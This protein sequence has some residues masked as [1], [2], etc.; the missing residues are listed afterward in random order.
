[1]IVDA[2]ALIGGYPLRPQLMGFAELA[3]SMEKA[4]VDVAAAVSLRAIYADSRKGNDRL[5][6]LAAQDPRIIPIGV[7]TPHTSHLDVPTLVADCVG[8]GAAGLAFSMSGLGVGLGSLSFRHTLAE[9]AKSRLPL[10]V[11]GLQSAGAPTQVAEMTRDLGCPVFL[12]GSPY[13]VFDELLAVLDAH[14]HIYVDTSWQVTPGCIELLVRHA[15]PGRVLFGSGAPIR[16][17][18]PALNVVL[19]ADIDA[20]TKQRI[21]AGNALR[22][23]G[24][25]TEAARLE[26]SPVSL[27]QV[28]VP[29]TSVIDVHCH[30]GIIPGIPATRRGVEAI[31]YYVENSN[32]EYVVCSSPIAYLE[33]LEAG[34]QEVLTN[35]KGRPRLLGSPSVSPLHL[36][37]STKWLDLCCQ[38][39]RLVHVTLSPHSYYEPLG[40]DR[41][42]QLFEEAAKRGVPVFYNGGQR[43]PVRSYRTQLSGGG[44]PWLRGASPEEYGMFV[45][46]GRRYPELPVI[47]GHS[48]GE[49]G[50]RLAKQTRNI[51]LEF[52]GTHPE[53]DAVRQAI[54]AVGKERVVFGSD[55]DLISPGFALGIYY[56]AVMS[57][58]E[59]R[60]VMSENAR[61]ILHLP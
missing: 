33:D 57:A 15:G 30:F 50:I 53:R 14:D 3:A 23:F 31:D 48:F 56:E 2:H 26:S 54:D 19:E 25:E 58:E 11:Y 40:S 42:L 9:A 35:L 59:E 21:L 47:I 60:L 39:H 45:E 46:V 16:P 61:R 51:Y 5:F 55:V 24:R 22:L 44:V 18:Q 7:V 37:E 52:S 4:G 17:I 12:V 32:V 49:D 43:D 1:M 27:P 8:K 28:K 36:E 29:A 38:G 34:N 13:H 10:V 41:Y 6:A 20:V